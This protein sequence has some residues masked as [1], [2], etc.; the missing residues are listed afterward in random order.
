M[1]ID[2]CIYNGEEEMLRLRMHE[3][4]QRAERFVVVEATTTFTGRP[5]EAGLPA[6]IAADARVRHIVV[7][8]LP[9]GRGAWPCE[10]HQRNA[11]L[12]GLE[13]AADNDLVLISDVDEIPRASAIP[14]EWPH[15]Q[16]GV[17]EQRFYYYDW[18]TRVRGQ[19]RGTRLVTV[20]TARAWHPQR[21]RIA[22]GQFISNGGWHFSYQGGPAA[23]RAKL[24]AFAHQE[25]NRP[26]YTSLAAI[27]RR[28]AA[29]LDL[30]D[31]PEM[32]LERVPLDDTY[33]AYVR[34]RYA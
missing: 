11:I 10:F 22:G 1:L 18:T 6:D 19:W 20:A 8:D 32:Q 9:V 12:R 5:R 29:G 25:Y 24:L 31:R 2:A 30:F 16:C 28:V 3:L 34:E 15:G 26:E 7:D 33:P 14:A 27:K 13:G 23:I 4:A 21:V 17:F